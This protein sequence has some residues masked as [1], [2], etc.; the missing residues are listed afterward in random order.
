MLVPLVS[1]ILLCHV[2]FCLASEALEAQVEFPCLASCPRVSRMELQRHGPGGASP[3]YLAILGHA[4]NLSGGERFYARGGSYAFLAGR[5]ATRA[6]ALG[7]TRA[8]AR[9]EDV[10]DLG[11]VRIGAALQWLQ[12]L[13]RRYGFVGVVAGGHFYDET[14]SPTVAM[15]LCVDKLEQRREHA[16]DRDEWNRKFPLCS[17]DGRGIFWCSD[18]AATPI[19]A[20]PPWARLDET[21]SVER[22][23]RRRRCACV[24]EGLEEPVAEPAFKAFEDCWQDG[25]RYKCRRTTSR[26]RAE[27]LRPAILLRKPEL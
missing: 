17:T 8:A 5:D 1:M 26:D 9:T 12:E 13:G 25:L 27:V 7:T 11:A 21:L 4:L 23:E 6:Y 19:M 24:G 22:R 18:A 10:S 20:L 16:E 15:R 3:P 14:G 2:V